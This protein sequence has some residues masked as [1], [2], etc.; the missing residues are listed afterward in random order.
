[1]SPLLPNAE[2]A[3]PHRS[4]PH[5]LDVVWAHSISVHVAGGWVVDSS[6]GVARQ[7]DSQGK[8]HHSKMRD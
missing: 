5:E 2:A 8:C 7:N 1:M 3:G 6:N 4:G